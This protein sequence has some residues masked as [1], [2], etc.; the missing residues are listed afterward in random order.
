MKPE[1][2]SKDRKPRKWFD[3]CFFEIDGSLSKSCLSSFFF[4]RSYLFICSLY[5]LALFPARLTA[6]TYFPSSIWENIFLISDEDIISYRSDKYPEI[7]R[8]Y[9]N[10][11]ETHKC[12]VHS[13][14]PMRV[15]YFFLSWFFSKKCHIYVGKEISFSI[16]SFSQNMQINKNTLLVFSKR[17]WY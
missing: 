11:N 9:N 12:E 7:Y 16:I 8:H 10:R 1:K 14:E 4:T 6:L 17:V 2:K 5:L 13:K 3:K 15:K